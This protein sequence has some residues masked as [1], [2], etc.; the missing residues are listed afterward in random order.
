MVASWTIAPPFHMEILPHHPV[1]VISSQALIHS[2]QFC[3]TFD[4]FGMEYRYEYRYTTATG[5]SMFLVILVLNIILSLNQKLWLFFIIPKYITSVAQYLHFPFTFLYSVI[6]TPQVW[7]SLRRRLTRSP[8]AR[9]MTRAL[10]SRR[11]TTSSRSSTTTTWRTPWT[12]T[13]WTVLSHLSL[14]RHGGWGLENT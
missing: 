2:T 4:T 11:S 12:R 8:R 9:T 1:N 3:E 7:R 13:T 6:L 5:H 10:G 14:T